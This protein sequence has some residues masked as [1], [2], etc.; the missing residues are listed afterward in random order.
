MVA[1][2]SCR[3][4]R[5]GGPGPWLPVPWAGQA[6]Q[7]AP[8]PSGVRCTH[9]GLCR[10]C[11]FLF[12]LTSPPCSC[13]LWEALSDPFSFWQAPS[14]CLPMRWFSLPQ[15]GALEGTEGPV[16]VEKQ[17]RQPN[18]IP[19][20]QSSCAVGSQQG[21]GQRRPRRRSKGMLEV[22]AWPGFPA[23]STPF[24]G[25]LHVPDMGFALKN[26]FLNQSMQE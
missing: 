18:A 8:T 10:Q 6:G 15:G 24:L 25:V 4:P 2:A 22:S 5:P 1:G 19:K 16:Q 12:R 20:G 9:P 17:R 7:G 11:S 26:C 14:V 23:P 3:T 21:T 13:L